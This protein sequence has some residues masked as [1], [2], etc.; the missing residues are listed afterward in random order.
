MEP[1]KLVATLAAAAACSGQADDQKTAAPP[2]R[3][4]AT[5]DPAGAE[6]GEQLSKLE[7]EEFAR[8]YLEHVRE[9]LKARERAARLSD[10]RGRE[11]RRP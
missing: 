6:I 11:S 10:F 7:G 4:V 5:M 8:A 3:C 1:L 9:I 2:P